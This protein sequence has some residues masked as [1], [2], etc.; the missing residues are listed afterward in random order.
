MTKSIEEMRAYVAKS[1]YDG[2]DLKALLKDEYARIVEDLSDWTDED[3]EEE[4]KDLTIGVT[5]DD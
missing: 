3:I 4:Y 1:H 2:I 5:I